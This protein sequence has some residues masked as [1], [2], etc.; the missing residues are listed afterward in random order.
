M[1]NKAWKIQNR[2]I[3]ELIE[4]DA[5]VLTNLTNTDGVAFHA[6]AA[7]TRPERLK[8]AGAIRQGFPAN[9]ALASAKAPTWEG[10]L[11]YAEEQG[12]IARAFLK[13]ARAVCREMVA[14]R[15][16]ATEPAAEARTWQQDD[17]V[18]RWEAIVRTL[19]EWLWEARGREKALGRDG[20]GP[21]ERN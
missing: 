18:E 21:R 7:E 17:E 6:W 15:I 10:W 20:G 9:P 5:E 14:K 3:L 16:R 11:G 4:E 19:Q 12:A 2:Q 8:Y 13:R 1:S